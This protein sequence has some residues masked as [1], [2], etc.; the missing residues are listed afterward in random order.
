[1]L[2]P[3]YAQQQVQEFCL[4]FN[5]Q[6][7]SFFKWCHKGASRANRAYS[8]FSTPPFPHMHMIRYDTTISSRMQRVLQTHNNDGLLNFM[9][10][11]Q[12]R[13]FSID[14][15]S[16]QVLLKDRL[17][18]IPFTINREQA[19]SAYVTY[20]SSSP[21]LAPLLQHEAVKEVFLPFWVM[22][23]SVDVQ[24]RSA[25]VGYDRVV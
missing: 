7:T 11:A 22:S 9:A 17:K 3:S 18:F 13:F 15:A 24:L 1:M 23:G 4:S 21:L 19:E 6:P 25:Q 12:L 10:S 2:L 16:H 8:A 5:P 20:H 14:A